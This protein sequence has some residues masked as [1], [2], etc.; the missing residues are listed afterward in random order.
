MLFRSAGTNLLTLTS[1]IYLLT[2]VGYVLQETLARAFYARQEPLLPFFAV[3]VR[4]FFYILIGWVGVQVVFFRAYGAPVLAAAELYLLAEALLMLFW[5]N[6][7]IKPEVN[8]LPALGKG[9]FAALISGGAAY[10]IALFLPGPGYL[11]AL[12]G[13]AAGG[14][15]ALFLVRSE[16]RLLFRL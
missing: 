10:E 15:M 16:V 6:Q 14:L 7:R 1:R 9:L 4:L 11:T 3:L 12:V 5:L 2:L 13:M 8:L